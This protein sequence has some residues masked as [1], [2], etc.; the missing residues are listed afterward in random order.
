MNR[1]LKTAWGTEITVW[2]FVKIMC[3]GTSLVTFACFYLLACVWVGSDY[4]YTGGWFMFL[5]M[6]FMPIRFKKLA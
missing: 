2:Q 6:L 5:S 1:T 3:A 4:S